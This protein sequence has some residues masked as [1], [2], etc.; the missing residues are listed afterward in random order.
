MNLTWIK[1]PQIA[2]CATMSAGKSTLI[3]ALL[4]IGYVP[5][6]NFSCTAKIISLL[7]YSVGDDLIAGKLTSDGKIVEMP[8]RSY[9]T[10]RGWN[11]DSEISQ[12]YLIGEL[13]N[14]FA[15]IVLNDTPGTN[16]SHHAEHSEITQNFLRENIPSLIIFV[17]NAE[18]IGTT[19]EKNLL[20]WL[21]TEIIEKNSAEIVFAINK[22]DSFDAEHENI[23]ATIFGIEKYL[24]DLGFKNFNMFPIAAESALL[25][26]ML[27]NHKRF[28]RL[29]SI[30]LKFLYD[31]FVEDNFQVSKD[32]KIQPFSGED[33]NISFKGEN[34]KI[35]DLYKAIQKTG[36][37]ELEKFI[38][39]K[40]GRSDI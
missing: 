16:S 27:I 22:L 5:S 34:Y 26:R 32:L 14:I 33:R 38:E 36:I 39:N 23:S 25:F 18:N 17:I 1:V 35:S 8:V 24:I 13:M 29:E 21:K 9:K 19:D 37:C 6:S 15:P 4:G 40:F 7:N 30:R 10:L 20:K 3:N 28:T 31:Y 12:I 2:L 11:D